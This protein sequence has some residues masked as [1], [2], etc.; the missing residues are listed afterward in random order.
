VNTFQHRILW[1]KI[2]D[3][4]LQA[5]AH[6]RENSAATCKVLPFGSNLAAFLSSQS[7]AQPEFMG[8]QTRRHGKHPDAMINHLRALFDNTQ[9]ATH[10]VAIYNCT[11]HFI[12]HKSRNKTNIS[13]QQLHAME[14]CI[15]H[16]IKVQVDG[17][18]SE[19]ISQICRCP[20]SHSW[21]WRDRWNDW[22]LVKQRPWGC[23]GALNG[24]FPWQL[25]WLFNINS[26]T[27]LELLLS[28]G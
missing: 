4:T 7:Y 21:R 19:C 24:R 13:D 11:G 2:R 22:V 27:R 10:H 12:K 8:P 26:W 20:R 16:G 17:L 28:T 5:L 9:E 23:N 15:F 18:E 25:Q 3:L 1:F 14:L 6:H